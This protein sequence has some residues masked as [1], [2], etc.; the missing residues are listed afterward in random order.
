[1]TD[2]RGGRYFREARFFLAGDKVAAQSH[3]GEARMLMGYMRDQL[4][5]GGPAI[6]VKYAT[7][8]DG[9]QIKATMMN[10][11]YQ[12]Q[13]VSPTFAKP[14]QAKSSVVYVRPYDTNE[15]QD[16]R[17][18]TLSDDDGCSANSVLTDRKL[19]SNRNWFSPA[20]DIVSILGGSDWDRYFPAISGAQ[21]VVNGEIV[22][23]SGTGAI[24]GAAMYNGALV[25][26]RAAFATV[27]T[28]ST[29]RTLVFRVYVGGVLKLTSP[30]IS[31]LDSTGGA[32]F[33]QKTVV[34]DSSG[35]V[36]VSCITPFAY[37]RITLTADGLGDVTA[38]YT[39]V[40]IPDTTPVANT[41]SAVSRHGVSSNTDTPTACGAPTYGVQHDVTG[42]K[43]YTKN[44]SASWPGFTVALAADFAHGSNTLR[45]LMLSSSGLHTASTVDMSY[46]LTGRVAACPG[47]SDFCSWASSETD[48]QN[49]SNSHR[50]WWSGTGE[51]AWSAT[52]QSNMH[53]NFSA[54][55]GNATAYDCTLTSAS[56]SYMTTSTSY[57]GMRVCSLDIRFK[58]GLLTYTLHT[59]VS[60]GE[61]ITDWHRYTEGNRWETRLRVFGDVQADLAVWNVVD[62]PVTTGDWISGSLAP[63]Y[64]GDD[65]TATSTT[66]AVNMTNG[67]TAVDG[68]T[69]RASPPVENYLFCAPDTPA[70][71]FVHIA[72]AVIPSSVRKV[73][74]L[75]P[76]G[77]VRDVTTLFPVATGDITTT[78]FGV[79]KE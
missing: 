35:S 19:Y 27:Y 7:L 23:G 68:W 46:S 54:S 17:V 6:Q 63:Y 3:I 40:A 59:Y 45:F 1:M 72:D 39:T 29:H 20:G 67:Y 5:L 64:P 62:N 47:V 28:P 22:A 21:L 49:S 25:V 32:D 44:D 77:G 8:Q 76:S 74:L 61:T 12:A 51:T 14:K 65:D 53:G 42:S 18:T 48:T 60:G 69:V 78:H 73:H 38:A 34:F 4:A 13:I 16:W 75:C 71:A 2:E 26:V 30:T 58:L 33:T 41:V 79:A 24:W 43:S 50:L 15:T 9:T 66:T 55:G 37:I 10:G 11:Q 52:A 57:N 36:G 31:S 56:G 70:L